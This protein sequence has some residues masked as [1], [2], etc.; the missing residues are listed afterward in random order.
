MLE[1][2]RRGGR[3]SRALGFAG[4]LSHAGQGYGA[5]S[6]DAL[7]AVARHE[8]GVLA[9]LADGLRASNAPVEEISVGATPT[10]RFIADQPGVTEMRPGNYVFFDRT[11][12]ALGAASFEDCALHVISTVVS[13]PARDR[14]IFDAGSKTLTN[15]GARG[16]GATPGH[17]LVFPSLSSDA[18]G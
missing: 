1:A 18:A 8:A 14:V 9:R 13:R 4:L 12:V 5:A 11:Q 2:I 16:F 7:R 10:S 3:A 6:V 17:G 15:D